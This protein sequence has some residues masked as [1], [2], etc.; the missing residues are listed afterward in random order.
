MNKNTLF[1]LLICIGLFPVLLQ[2]QMS[3]LQVEADQLNYETE[4]N[5][6]TATG[7]VVLRKGAQSLKADIITYNQVT[8]QAFARGH[9]VFSDETQVWRGETL[10][11]N[12]ITGKG[13]FP[14]LQ[15]ESGPFK[16]KADQV[17][18]LG[19]I[20]TQLQGVTVTT[21]PDPEDPDFKIRA[22]TVDAYEEEIYVMRNPVFYLHGIPFF[23]LPRL[24]LD[25][26]RKPTNVDV[27]PGYSSRDGLSLLNSFSRYPKDGYRTKTILDFRSER[28][29][30]AGQNFYWYN[31]ET[32]RDHTTLK[33]YGA[34]DDSPY[35]NDT[36]QTEYESQ[37]ITVEEE[38]YRIKFDTRQEITPTDTFWAK[39]SYLSDAKV[40]EDFF[41][42]DYRNEPVPETRVAYSAV[43]NIWNANIDLTRQLNQDEF[44][45]VNKL[46]EATF[47]VPLVKMGDLE[48]MYESETKAGYLERTYSEFQR[49][50]GSED[51]DSVRFYTDHMFYYPTKSF[52]WLNITPR[53]GGNIT[54]YGNTQNTETKVNTSSTADENGI[55]TT[56]FSTNTVTTVES[57][58]VRVLPQFGFET[59]FKA[60]GIVHDQATNLGRGL[61]HVVEPFADYTYV[62]ESDLTPDKIFQFDDIDELGEEHTLEF[63]IRNKWQT[64]RAVDNG[65]H[66]IHDLVNTALSTEYDLRSDADPSLGNILWD[67]ELKLADW[68]WTRFDISW[69]T[70]ESQ[71]DSANAEVLFKDKHSGNYIS[72]NQ[73][74]RVDDT[75]TTQL[76]YELN[77]KGKLGF[78]GYTR[79]EFEDAGFEEQHVMFTIQTDCIG[80]GIGGKWRLGDR[81]SDGSSDEDDYEL[82]LQFWLTA[83]PRAVLGTGS[84]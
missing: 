82:W 49:D 42:D 56:S 59:S 62:P 84:R 1:S 50:N 45:S 32:N 35:R 6:V 26:Q 78:K 47:N 20:Q 3:D 76:E 8:E 71:T 34:L 48:M 57:A 18:R 7:N 25:P 12:F 37:G 4:N 31:P 44:E 23:Y 81:Y 40:V 61:R 70:D 15:G 10:K 29:F 80:Y 74:Y 66:Q 19:P 17:E 51:Y 9:V 2:A 46:P 68:V 65:H 30:A 28:G 24:T 39:A 5:L 83:F 79:Y 43:G 27:I 54:Y 60:F 77:P 21:C 41:E 63:G 22:K 33:F 16:L 55:I 58:D 53:L 36:Q 52:G 73:R 13:S 72:L 14:G 11:Y 64:K 67:T 75:N 69:D 38:R